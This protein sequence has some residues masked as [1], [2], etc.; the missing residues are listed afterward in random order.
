MKI[1]VRRG[2]RVSKSISKNSVLTNIGEGNGTGV[3]MSVKK[4]YA[5]L[6]LMAEIAL[7]LLI[8][9]HRRVLSNAQ[10]YN[11]NNLCNRKERE[12]RFTEKRA[13]I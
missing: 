10:F 5:I 13:L 6:R 7:R 9:Q 1:L 12:F 8:Q 11:V 4:S 3:Q 2:K